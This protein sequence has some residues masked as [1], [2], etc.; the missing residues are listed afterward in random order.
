MLGVTLVGDALPEP[1]AR[2]YNAIDAGRGAA[3]AA[4]FAPD[5]RLALPDPAAPLETSPRLVV[6][7]HDAIAG[8][9][10]GRGAPD[11]HHV[12]DVCISEG[13]VCLLEGTVVRGGREAM[14]F[15]ASARLDGEGRIE[16][17]LVYA[18][19]PPARPAAAGL[20][21]PHGDK[22]PAD[23]LAVFD[24]YLTALQDG[25]LDDAIAHFGADALYS[26]PPYVHQSGGD[27]LEFRGHDGLRAGFTS[28]GPAP[29]RHDVVAVGQRGLHAI[30]EGVTRDLPPGRSAGRFISVISLDSTDHIARYVS[31]YCEPDVP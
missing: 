5:A 22:L 25:R 3:A 8:W 12:V 13:A 18:G 15:V 21:A 16:R 9:L 27:R 1:L 4:C 26:H 2:Y 14:T 19:K 6:A 20:V 24:S 31:F 30:V 7:G 28:R 17:Y 29:F 23:A 11:H 10:G